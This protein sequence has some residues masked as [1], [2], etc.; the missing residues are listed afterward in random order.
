M[1][2]FALFVILFVLPIY[3]IWKHDFKKVKPKIKKM[4]KTD[5]KF[6]DFFDE[7]RNHIR[8]VVGN[9][10]I[11][12]AGGNFVRYLMYHNINH[13]DYWLGKSIACK[14]IQVRFQLKIYGDGKRKIHFSSE[15]HYGDS[16]WDGKNMH[17]NYPIGFSEFEC[18]VNDFPSTW[19]KFLEKV[20]SID[21]QADNMS[22][23]VKSGKMSYWTEKTYGHLL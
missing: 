21:P 17:Y 19:I 5:Y 16:H 6:V 7:L 18:D 13:E 22:E 8:D 1:W 15:S 14:Y 9:E 2:P 4:K 23:R 11:D 12:Y 3:L 20:Y 10:C